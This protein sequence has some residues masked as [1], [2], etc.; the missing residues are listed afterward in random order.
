M[1]E[2]AD[3]IEEII[4]NKKPDECE[5]I[6][7]TNKQKYIVTVQYGVWEND[8]KTFR[9]CADCK[10]AEQKDSKSWGY[11]CK[12]DLIPGEEPP[13]RIKKRGRPKN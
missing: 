6:F 5:N 9:F 3:I 4:K 10:D 8:K 2:L 1:A 7:C 12:D 11:I 13:V